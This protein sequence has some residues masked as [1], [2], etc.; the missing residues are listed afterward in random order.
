MNDIILKKLYPNWSNLLDLKEYAR[1]NGREAV[2]VGM[3]TEMQGNPRLPIEKKLKDILPL[4]PDAT[5]EDKNILLPLKNETRK[6]LKELGKPDCP[7]I[8]Y[9]SDDYFES[10][11]K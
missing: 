2:A 1:Y 9:L 8:S 6:V 3:A 4:K 10:K 11:K 7:T 5:E